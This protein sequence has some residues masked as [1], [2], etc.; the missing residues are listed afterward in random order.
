[1]ATFVQA[2]WFPGRKY[3]RPGRIVHHRR[4]SRGRSLDPPI[5][6]NSSAIPK[7]PGAQGKC[8]CQA[9]GAGNPTAKRRPVAKLSTGGAQ[10][11][12]V[13][14]LAVADLMIHKRPSCVK[15]GA[16]RVNRRVCCRRSPGCTYDSGILVSGP[17]V[18]SVGS[19]APV[20]SDQAVDNALTPPDSTHTPSQHTL[21]LSNFKPL[22]T[23]SISGIG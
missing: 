12:P 2:A 8:Q 13:T 14:G 7:S 1:M 20:H 11:T 5:A 9:A 18:N 17:M 16:G 4:R 6:G 10:P 3:R 21:L 15:G 23:L 22:L 19:G